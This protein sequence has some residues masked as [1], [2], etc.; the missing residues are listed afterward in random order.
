M[1][2]VL[3]FVR[4]PEGA[5]DQSV[6]AGLLDQVGATGVGDLEGVDG[7]VHGSGCSLSQ[8]SHFGD[9]Y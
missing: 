1:Y 9:V 4:A 5:L 6:A 2:L 3:A 8:D 7:V